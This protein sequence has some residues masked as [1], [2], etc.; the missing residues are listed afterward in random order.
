MGD[1]GFGGVFD[2][3]IDI[4]EEPKEIGIIATF[5]SV[6]DFWVLKQREGFDRYRKD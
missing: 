4:I 3:G 6:R 5:L 2:L 1:I